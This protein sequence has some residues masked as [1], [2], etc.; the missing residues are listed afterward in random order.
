LL[1]LVYEEVSILTSQQ[2]MPLKDAKPGHKR[3]IH[4]VDG[5]VKHRKSFRDRGLE[6]FF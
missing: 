5:I 6:V 3:K 2:E 1:K 4:G